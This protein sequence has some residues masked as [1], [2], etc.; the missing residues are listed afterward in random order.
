MRI[1]YVSVVAGLT[2]MINVYV[3]Q[4][5]I[6]TIIAALVF[7]DVQTFVKLKNHNYLEIHGTTI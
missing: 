4:I 1:G 5:T 7:W 3:H 2:V 6:E